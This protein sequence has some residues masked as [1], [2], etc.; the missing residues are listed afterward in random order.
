MIGIWDK[1]LARQELGRSLFIVTTARTFGLS[2]WK[3][4]WRKNKLSSNTLS[5]KKQ[6]LCIKLTFPDIFL[7]F[8]F[9]SLLKLQK[10]F[11]R[12]NVS[13]QISPQHQGRI[14]VWKWLRKDEF[15]RQTSQRHSIWLKVWTKIEVL[16]K[17]IFKNIY[18]HSFIAF[19][20]ILSYF[21]FFQPGAQ[22]IE[23]HNYLWLLS[24]QYPI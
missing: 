4:K 1:S 20:F 9:V 22:R 19:G 16:H 5:L 8:L 14:T 7:I 6:C 23:M 12:K 15:W 10:I 17:S 18:H 24:P 2:S 13:Y 21:I 3:A 11:K